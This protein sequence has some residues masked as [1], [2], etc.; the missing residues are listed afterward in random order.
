MSKNKTKQI[1]LETA[2]FFIKSPP[3]IKNRLQA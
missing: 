2:W 3:E 1:I